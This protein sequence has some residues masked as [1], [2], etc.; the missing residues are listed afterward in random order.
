M[1]GH[2]CVRSS[3]G[4]PTSTRLALLR[5][6]PSP[7]HVG[8]P[9]LPHSRILK[10]YG[11]VVVQSKL[12]I[13]REERMFDLGLSDTCRAT[14]RDGRPCRQRAS[15]LGFCLFHDPSSEA[16]ERRVQNARTAGKRSVEVRRE[17][18]KRAR[19]LGPIELKTVEDALTLLERTVNEVRESSLDTPRARLQIKAAQAF[20]HHSST[21]EVEERIRS[22]EEL[23]AEYGLDNPTAALRVIETKRTLRPLG[24][25]RHR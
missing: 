25:S 21:R 11:Q 20:L 19:T 23:V 10:T 3:I 13:Q 17:R 15:V 4:E 6:K 16:K 22:L 9:R 5:T 14:R 8:H 7:V 2:R 1:Q 18:K 12:I 24:R